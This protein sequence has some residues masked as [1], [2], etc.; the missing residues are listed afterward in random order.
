MGTLEIKQGI[1]EQEFALISALNNAETR[2]LQLAVSAV[3]TCLFK[4]MCFIC[5]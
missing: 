3:A 2:V 1:C 5:P 4:R